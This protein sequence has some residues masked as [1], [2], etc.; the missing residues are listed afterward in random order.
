MYIYNKLDFWQPY[1]NCGHFESIENLM[2]SYNDAGNEL[3][4]PY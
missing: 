1:G 3:W 2:E 4:A